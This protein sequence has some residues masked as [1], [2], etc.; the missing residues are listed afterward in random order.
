MTVQCFIL[1]YNETFRY[2]ADHYGE[3]ALQGLWDEISSRWC[4]H[5]EELVAEKRL[6]GMQEYWGGN[7]GTLSREKAVYD[8]NLK[9]GVFALNMY[10]CPS[11]GE[12]VQ[13]GRVPLHGGLNY[14]DHCPALYVP[15]ARRNGCDMTIEI[16][17]NEDG[18][19][20][21]RCKLRAWEKPES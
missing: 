18:T 2:I 8:T 19:C 5:L 13:H 11:V 6:E 4:C 17:Y 20:A 7:E 14:C 16:E 1:L 21:G 10:N 12:L 15:V 3:E 9:D